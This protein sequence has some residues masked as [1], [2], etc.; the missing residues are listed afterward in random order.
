LH[1]SEYRRGRLLQITVLTGPTSIELDMGSSFRLDDDALFDLCA[2]NPELRLERS[3]AGDLVVRTAAGWESDRRNAEIVYA[4]SS[5]AKEDGTG[6]VADSSTGFLLPNGA[7][8]AP[9]AAWV[10]RSRLEGVSPE[11]KERFLPLCPDFVIELRSP[12]DALPDLLAKMEEYREA[13]ARLGW[14]IDSQER[15]IHVFRPDRPTEVLDDPAEISGDP[16]LPG[17]TLS[18]EPLWGAA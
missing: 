3:G 10:E 11:Q 12:S 8:R 5:W 7:M 15:R 18:L 1:G 14:L 16:E 2:R 6:V 17:F 13:G 9:D 4:L